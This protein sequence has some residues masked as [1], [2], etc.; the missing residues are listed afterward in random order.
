MYFLHH[1]FMCRNID[2]TVLLCDRGSIS[3]SASCWTNS[4]S[5]R[6]PV[7]QCDHLKHYRQLEHL[8][9][10][11]QDHRQHY[12]LDFQHGFLL[13]NIITL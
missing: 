11:H 12:Q 6:V 4:C 13:V 7:G 8:T 10:F 2:L 3:T 9:N 5:T 1:V